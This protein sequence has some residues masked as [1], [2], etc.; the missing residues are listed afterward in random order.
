MARTAPLALAS[1]D[2]CVR[3]L[4]VVIR[5]APRAKADTEAFLSA[6]VAILREVIAPHGATDFPH[7]SFRLFVAH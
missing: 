7:V 5:L 6:P 4:G 2:V 3:L 1:G